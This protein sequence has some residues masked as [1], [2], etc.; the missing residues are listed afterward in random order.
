[1]PSL[2]HAGHIIV[3][4]CCL[5]HLSHLAWCLVMPVVPSPSPCVFVFSAT[6]SSPLFCV[7]VL[8]SFPS[9]S[10]CHQR[11]LFPP[12]EQMLTAAV[13]G[14]DVVAVIVTIIPSPLLVVIVVA[15]SLLFIVVFSPFPSFIVIPHQ[16]HCPLAP[17][18]HQASSCSQ[19]WMWVLSF[20]PGWAISGDMAGLQC[21]WVLTFWVSHWMGHLVPP[22]GHYHSK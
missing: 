5:P 20:S 12:Y 7:L 3:V 4:T 13:V 21:G 15:F 11:S 17:T 19:Q 16:C 9:L 14:A 10:H 2:L 18:F 8:S 1:V 22:W 6:P